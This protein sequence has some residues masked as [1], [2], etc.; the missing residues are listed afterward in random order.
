IEQLCDIHYPTIDITP[1]VIGI[2]SFHPGGI[3]NMGGAYGIPEP[4]RETFN[5]ACDRIG[6]ISS[7]SIRHM[8]IRPTGVLPGGCPR[9]IEYAL[10]CKQHERF[11]GVPAFPYLTLALGDF[12][13]RT[14]QVHGPGFPCCLGLER[15]RL[16]QCP[17]YFEYAHAVPVAFQ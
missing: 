8:A 10:L 7:R 16:T 12:I 11:L 17:I 4:R 5:L 13:E 1:D 6:H 9:R 2:I 15:D 3:E 14:A